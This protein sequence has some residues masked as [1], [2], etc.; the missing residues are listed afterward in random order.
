MD[1][2]QLGRLPS[3][4]PCPS[5]ALCAKGVGVAAAKHLR[6]VRSSRSSP[7]LLSSSTLSHL[8]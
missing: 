1:A 4:L 2:L 6:G 5:A 7:Q 8:G 3:A